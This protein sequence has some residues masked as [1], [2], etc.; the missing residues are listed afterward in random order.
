MVTFNGFS[1]I[2]FDQTLEILQ[3]KKSLFLF[4][5]TSARA[6]TRE[7]RVARLAGKVKI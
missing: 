1:C 6:T 7:T 4:K 5:A 3:E 2:E